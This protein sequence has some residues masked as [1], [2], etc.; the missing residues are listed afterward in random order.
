MNPTSRNGIYILGSTLI[1]LIIIVSAFY[2]FHSSPEKSFMRLV[3]TPI[4]KSVRQIQEKHNLAMDSAIWV[5]HFEMD[6][7]DLQELLSGQKF[8]PIDEISEYKQWNQNIKNYVQISKEEY[9]KSWAERIKKSVDFNTNMTKDWQ[10]YTVNEKR[11]EKYVF[12]LTNNSNAEI[13]F[14]AEVH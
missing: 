2:F 4:P 11:G 13:I 1:A 3:M 6:K 7:S 9:L 12:F 5:L 14:V 10:V 8:T